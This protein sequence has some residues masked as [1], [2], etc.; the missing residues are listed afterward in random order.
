[1]T[2]REFIDRAVI[3]FTPKGSEQFWKI[4]NAKLKEAILKG[5]SK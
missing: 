1:M 5:K 4:Y 3:G 2:D